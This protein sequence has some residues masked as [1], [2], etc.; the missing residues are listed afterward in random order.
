MP[1]V[2]TTITLTIAPEGSSLEALEEQVWQAVRNAALTLLQTAC[3]A[4][5]EQALLPSAEIRADKRR[6][7]SLLTRFGWLRL[8]RWYAQERVSGRYTYPL[9]RILQLGSRRHA[10]PW[11]IEQAIALATRLPYRQATRLLCKVLGEAGAVDHRTLY[12]WVQAEGQACIEAE[13]ERQAAVFRDGEAPACDGEVRELVVAEADGTFIK[14]Q[15]EGVPAF[16][17]RLGVL[18]SGRRLVSKTAKH[19]RYALQERVVY[20]GVETAE[21]FKERF[22]LAGEERLSLSL[23]RHLLVVG[24]GADWIEALAGH[25]RWRATYQ[26]DHWH[27]LHHA[28]L[29]FT[30]RPEAVTEIA[31]AL[32]A[33]DADRVIS[34]V[35]LA[36]LTAADPERVARF[37]AYLLANYH[38]IT[39]ARRLRRRLSEQ[40]RYVAVE[41]S[42]AIEKQSDLIVSRRFEGQGMRWTRRGAHRLLKLRLRELEAVA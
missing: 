21:A 31:E 18:Y 27:I 40:A 19:R 25:E 11:V 26:L 8:E 6:P 2:A 1:T 20:G 22:Y 13:D 42:G 34:L 3:R 28:R 24:D 16:E 12:A 35:K 23:A 17:L 37:E 38:G 4:M 30:D 7:L 36:R 32:H 41:G 39:G 10:S 9:D 5:E 15:R 33:G 29:T 14:A